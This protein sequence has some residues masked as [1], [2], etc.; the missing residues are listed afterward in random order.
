[1]SPSE[2]DW[3]GRIKLFRAPLFVG[4]CSTCVCV[5]D[6]QATWLVTQTRH[7]ESAGQPPLSAAEQQQEADKKPIGRSNGFPSTRIFRAWQ[8]RTQPIGRLWRHI[9]W[10]KLGWQTICSSWPRIECVAASPTD[11]VHW[12]ILLLG[13]SCLSKSVQCAGVGGQAL[14]F[15]IKTNEWCTLGMEKIE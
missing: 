10:I 5:D 4:L 13:T 8:T 9:R 11:Y 14:F 1:M 2:S 7:T 15:G 3:C 12:Q 6:G